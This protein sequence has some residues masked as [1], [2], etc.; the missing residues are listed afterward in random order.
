[1]VVAMKLTPNP[2]DVLALSSAPQPEWA[3]S[4]TQ[5]LE[6]AAE[7]GFSVELRAAPETMTPLQAARRLS[8]SRST[9]TRKI[10]EGEIAAFRVG[11]RYRI[12]VPEV[13]RYRVSMM[14]AMA[15]MAQDDIGA[16]L[17]LDGHT[18]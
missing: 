13:E 4:L 5:F 1:M 9:V 2:S 14:V 16:E 6:D 15:T 3:A 8:I 10:Q 18:A 12:P 11:N 17:G 7:Q